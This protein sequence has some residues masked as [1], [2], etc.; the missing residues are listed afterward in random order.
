MDAA[1]YP[2]WNSP[3]MGP[4]LKTISP[5]KFLAEG[6]G[7][8]IRDNAGRWYIDAR[9][10]LWNVSLGYDH[11]GL[12][13]AV[14]RQVDALPYANHLGYGAP[15][16]VA[17]EAAHALLPHLP[18]HFRA[19]RYCS[20]GSQAVETAV[21][22]SRFLHRIDGAPER[23]AV[24]G[25]WRGFHG[26]GSGG[27]ALSGIPYVHHHCGPLLPDVQH[28][29]GPFEPLTADGSADFQRMILDFGSERVAA[30][31]VEPV[32]GEGGHVLNDEYLK[33]LV[34]FTR[35]YGIHLIVDEITT[36]M[37]RTGAFTRT[38][39][40]GIRPDIVT[41]GK[42]LSGGYAPLSAV[43][44]SSDIY[45]RLLEL[46]HNRQI[47]LGST[48]DGHPIGLAA[49]IA[50]VS[51]LADGVLDNVR[52][53]SAQLHQ[54]LKEIQ[55]RH[56]IVS[57]VRGAGLM[58]GVELG[59]HPDLPPPMAAANLLRLAL[60]E[61]GVLVSGLAVWP[62]VMIVPPL[63][64][65]PTEIAE[66]ADALDR[67]LDGLRSMYTKHDSRAQEGSPGRR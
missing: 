43:V 39:Q 34:R 37:G 7:V 30:V 10:G 52:E 8:R 67:A 14:K 41:L 27:G 13:E 16:A 35:D 28:A 21:L 66:I 32:V 63:V 19:I 45:N 17:V 58:Y 38:G 24:F 44:L 64:I 9:S 18:D 40:V 56:E 61:R 49:S 47:F 62:A 3:A 31:V 20:N 46:P 26:L 1:E 50:V 25:M 2:L 4:Y 65:S 11:A 60:A 54:A 53:R 59:E 36:G 15:S 23:H 55:A 22:L 42:G 6:R 51:A 33:S 48:S 57:A 5:D 12:R 29:P